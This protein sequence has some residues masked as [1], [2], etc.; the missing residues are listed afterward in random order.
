MVLVLNMT[1]LNLVRAEVD[2][3]LA[4]VEANL[5]AFVEER[6]NAA[7]LAQCVEGLEQVYG[8]LRL[9]ELPGAVELSHALHEL[10]KQVA[11]QGA[12][13]ADEDFAALGNG[14]M[15][16]GR[17]LEYVQ[18]KGGA[19]PQLLIPTI[20]QVQL[21][22]GG[23]PFPEGHF[24]AISSL[25][26]APRQAALELSAGQVPALLR[27]LRLMYQT[28]LIAI[29][30][31]QADTPHFRMMSR[32]AERAQQVVAGKPLSLLWWSAAAM[33]EAMQNGV[34]INLARKTVLGQLDRQLK[35]MA[36]EA[37]RNHLDLDLLKSCLYV[38]GVTE[39]GDKV[40]QVSEAFHLADHCLT[41]SAMAVEYELMC[42][43]GGSVIKTVAQVLQDEL[44]HVKDSLDMMARGAQND[45]DSYTAMADN[46]QKT[47][48]TLVMLG[49]L[50][51]SKAMREQSEQVRQ[52]QGEPASDALHSLVDAL[53][54]V[55]NAV[56]GLVKQVT[57]GVETPIH[58]HRISIHQLDEARALLVAESR[59]GMSLA[60]RAISSYLESNRDLMHLANVPATLQSVA[61]GLSFLLI[62]RGAE[63]L[64]GCARFIDQKML[65][66][67]PEQQPG[68]ADLETLADAI[69]SVDYYLES[70]E[71]NKPISESILDIAEESLAELGYPVT[72]QEAA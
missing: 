1:S 54:G 37:G 69:S 51:A 25:P 21:R 63:I 32:A 62:G 15:V 36:T 47:S 43:P 14:I 5:G 18:I 39:S 24:L 6:Q 56:A 60:K 71:T 64:R 50:D 34:A 53:L 10:M 49:L 55:E 17:Y 35:A 70:L 72:K 33:I 9:I 8:A 4:Q 3:T 28:G 68:M 59:S 45:S 41:E 12:E 67:E 26:A 42:G 29:L 52:W 48:Q 66:T 13:A 65:N 16:L 11:T 2:A 40:R 22:L 7:A 61:G 57:P 31:D 19:W 38:V 27:R 44:A 23:K 58:N 46:L 20:N 30:R